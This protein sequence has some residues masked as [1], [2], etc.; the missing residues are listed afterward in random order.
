MYDYRLY[1]KW[2]MQDNIFDI[3]F[4]PGICTQVTP[5]NWLNGKY[6]VALEK[7]YMNMCDVDFGEKFIEEVDI[8][9]FDLPR[10]YIT[11]QSES[12][13]D[14]KNYDA[15]EEVVNRINQQKLKIVH[16][17]ASRDKK[18]DNVVD[19]RGKTTWQEAASIIKN[20]E[21]H[22]GLDSVLMHFAAHYTVDSVILFGGTLPEAALSTYDRIYVDIIE[23]KDRGP[24]LTSCHLTECEVKKQGS[25]DKCINNIDSDFVTTVVSE[26]LRD[27]WGDDIIMPAEEIKLSAYMIIRNGVEYGYPFEECIKAAAKICD[28]VVVVDGGSTDDTYNK[29][30]ELGAEDEELLKTEFKILQ[31]KW[32]L[33]K[34]TLFGDEKTFARAQCTGTHLIQLD[35]DEIITEP[36]PGELKTIIKKNRKVDLLDLPCINFYGDDSTIRIEDNCWKWRVSKNDYNIIHGVHG[37]ARKFDIELACVTMDKKVSDGCEYIY[38]DSLKICDHQVAFSQQ[39]IMLHEA[40]KNPNYTNKYVD[41]YLK[42]LQEIINTVPVVFHYSWMDLDRKTQGGTFWD[43]TFHGKKEETHNTTKDIQK[44]IEQNTDVLI[45][46]DFDHP[47]KTEKVE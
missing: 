18:L 20:A 7:L 2:A 33:D 40:V 16:I 8:Q 31:H 17:G 45:K 15:L 25:H 4:C 46:V 11:V 19:M 12:S 41:E 10:N 13:Q 6:A 14:P 39:L 30:K 42:L 38:Q 1:T 29:L 36:E 5:G 47:F 23:P 27:N 9:K 26:I 21:M 3:V 24:C 34:P 22:L 44:R 43:Q 32:D 28:E 37:E 35:C